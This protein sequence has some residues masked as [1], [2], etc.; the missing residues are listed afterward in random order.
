M[1]WEILMWLV[2]GVLLGVIAGWLL[3]RLFYRREQVDSMQINDS[4]LTGLQAERD[5]A[6]S[7]LHA[8]EASLAEANTAL[9]QAQKNLAD[10]QDRCAGLQ[11]TVVAHESTISDLSQ[12]LDRH[13]AAVA[14]GG[15]NVVPPVATDTASPGAMAP[16]AMAPG[17]TVPPVPDAAVP[18][19]S[20]PADIAAVPPDSDAADEIR[21][22]ATT[23]P[24]EDASSGSDEDEHPPIVGVDTVPASSDDPEVVEEAVEAK[25]AQPGEQPPIPDAPPTTFDEP[26]DLTRI[27]GI[28]KVLSGKLHG[29]GITTFAQIAA[30]TP[31]DAARVNAQL[32]F[33]GRVEREDWIAQAKKLAAED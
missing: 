9:A 19:V 18:S 22:G 11:D 25:A 24:K 26:D 33:K 15:G 23:T 17:D 4:R 16:P 10:C 8:S 13:Q 31:E 28:G 29:L 30:L 12:R 2:I 5:K 20:A 32:S 21:E 7:E 14:E 27:K 6:A 1:F 3:C